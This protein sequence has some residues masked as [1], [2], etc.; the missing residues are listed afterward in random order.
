LHGE[1]PNLKT[2]EWK[3][4]DGRENRGTSLLVRTRKK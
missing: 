3:G 1:E 4:S 2:L